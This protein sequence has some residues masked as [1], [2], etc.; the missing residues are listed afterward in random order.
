MVEHDNV[1]PGNPTHGRIREKVFVFSMSSPAELIE[2]V[3]SPYSFMLTCLW[4]RTSRQAHTARLT[5]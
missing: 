1:P 5:P 3:R 4:C 2:D